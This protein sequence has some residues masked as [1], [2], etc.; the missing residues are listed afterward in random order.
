VG[1]RVARLS[2]QAPTQNVDGSD[3]TDLAGFQIHWGSSSNNYTQ[4][5]AVDGAG[6]TQQVISVS[7]GTWYFAVTARDTD[8]HES[9]YSNEVSKTVN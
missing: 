7:P 9:A 4:H 8:G 5:T 3:L 2:W 1:I 6:T